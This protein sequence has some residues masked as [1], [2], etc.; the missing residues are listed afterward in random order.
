MIVKGIPSTR[1]YVH[2]ECAQYVV[3]ILQ[4]TFNIWFVLWATSGG[5]FQKGIFCKENFTSAII[6]EIDLT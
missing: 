2:V 6:L 4:V 3:Q 5:L 1:Q